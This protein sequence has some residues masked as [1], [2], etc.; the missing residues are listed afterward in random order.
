MPVE[1]YVRIQ[2]RTIGAVAVLELDGRLTANEPPGLLKAAVE[3]A[4]ARGSIDVV[5]DLTGVGY[6]D[7]TRLGEL[8]AAHVTVSRRGGRLT[9]AAVPPRVLEL[10]RMAGLENVFDRFESVG[11]AAAHLQEP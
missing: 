9:L 5:I 4:I 1:V 2:D 7:S 10:L 3:A 11:A 8:I 6:M